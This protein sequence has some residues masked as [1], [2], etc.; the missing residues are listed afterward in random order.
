MTVSVLVLHYIVS[1]G[2]TKIQVLSRHG[3]VKRV[4]VV[5]N[6]AWTK[7]AYCVK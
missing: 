4:G 3:V 6:E 5:R 2:G 7:F 1:I